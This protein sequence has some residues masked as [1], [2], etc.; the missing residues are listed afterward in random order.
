MSRRRRR[1]AWLV[2]GSLVAGS[3]VVASVAV[4]QPDAGGWHAQ[5]IRFAGGWRV[6]TLVRRSQ[7][8]SDTQVAVS[9]SGAAVLGWIQGRPPA[10]CSEGPCRQPGGPFRG[11]EVMASQGTAVGG[12]GRP[13]KLSANGD[14][15]VFAAQ[16]SS[17]ISYVAWDPYTGQGWRIVAIDQGRP[18][19]PIVL[20]ADAQLQG[21]F[22]G[23][24]REAAAVW[25]TPGHPWKLRYAFLDSRAQLGRQ[26]ILAAM[27]GPELLYPSIALND[28][29]DLAAV[30]MAGPKE[31]TKPAFMAMCDA[32]GRCT[33]PRGLPL[34]PA[35]LSVSVALTDQGAAFALE[36]SHSG[37]WAA[38]AHV[39]QARVRAVRVASTG[40][41]P[42]A[43]SDGTAGVAAT[44][45]PSDS[46]I[47]QTIFDPTTG[48]FTKPTIRSTAADGPFPQVAA[49]LTGRSVF[50][51]LTSCCLRV[52]SGSGTRTG[53][54]TDVP[55]STRA[56]L[57]EG[58][59]SQVQDGPSDQN[60]GI[61][62]RGNAVF[63]WEKP[64]GNYNRGLY[65]AVHRTG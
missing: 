1:L 37:L 58:F 8:V 51:W 57:T 46:A 53:R 47:A 22:T 34:P 48:R 15:Q 28:R 32:R 62:G 6:Q 24:E 29:G 23:P 40:S 31:F 27:K 56:D 18:S 60:I 11:F 59:N 26:G 7:F 54:A 39:D 49:S 3:L 16:V 30:W 20:P 25:A 63:T 61:D 10:V 42:L 64:G 43:V 9:E 14:G 17:G 35:F 65:A 5:T 12:F 38:I 45:M 50:T 2:A 52:A 44:F 55:A 4:S 21:L 33:H 19:R 41:W 13:I 36:G